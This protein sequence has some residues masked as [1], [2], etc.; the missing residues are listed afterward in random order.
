MKIKKE[1]GNMRT[2]YSNDQVREMLES[3]RARN[4]NASYVVIAER[5]GLTYSY[6]VGWKNKDRNMGQKALNRIVDFINE[7]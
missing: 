7:N 2:K 6:V 3:W 5:T 1:A 4:F